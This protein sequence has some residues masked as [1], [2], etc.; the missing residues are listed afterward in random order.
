MLRMVLDCS[1]AEAAAIEAILEAGQREG[2][3]CYGLHRS[4]KARMTCLVFSLDE[5][6]HVHFID[7]EGGG[8]A[9]AARD[10]KARLAA[11]APA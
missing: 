4:E 5:S 2:R 6:R 7:G 3:L 1:P 11:A 10:L 8:Y 9:L